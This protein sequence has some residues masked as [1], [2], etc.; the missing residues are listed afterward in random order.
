MATRT[1]QRTRPE[2]MPSPAACTC[3][4]NDGI[5]QH[6]CRCVHAT[7]SP[8]HARAHVDGHDNEHPVTTME[9]HDYVVS[10][11]SMASIDHA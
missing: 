3:V 5:K 6:P 9:S 8:S 4:K 10:S 7:L 1:E 2:G 11:S